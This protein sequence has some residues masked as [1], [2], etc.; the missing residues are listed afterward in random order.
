MNNL[1]LLGVVIGLLVALA[2]IIDGFSGFLWAL[3][4]GITGGLCAAHFE[5]RIDLKNLVSN[6]TSS[7][8]GRG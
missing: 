3:F 4:F 1:T 6:V 8:G 2:V 7:R 5:G